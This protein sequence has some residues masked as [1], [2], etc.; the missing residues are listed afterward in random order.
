LILLKRQYQQ[1]LYVVLCIDF[2][3]KKEQNLL[4]YKVNQPVKASLSKAE[5]KE[6]LNNNTFEI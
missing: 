5:N 3:Q 1:Y 4:N 2:S 6:I